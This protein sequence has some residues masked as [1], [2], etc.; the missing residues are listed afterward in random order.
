MPSVATP[1]C[2]LIALLLVVASHAQQQPKPAPLSAG[3]IALPKAFLRQPYHAELG[4]QGGVA[5]FHWAL[6]N[7]SLPPNMQLAPN[8]VVTGV[9]MLVGDFPFDATVTDSSAPPRQINQSLV[10][11]VVA[12]LMARWLKPPQV[13]GARI[14]GSIQV[15]NQTGE[16]FDLTEVVVAVNDVGRATALGY[17]HFT[18][19]KNTIDF[20]IPFGESPGPGTFEVN[21]DVVAEIPDLDVIHRVRLVGSQKLQIAGP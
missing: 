9:P 17:Q 13:N 15:S 12:P 16:D 21:V 10:L 19:Q 18:L 2:I 20:E 1:R 11:R 5:P 8:G 14:E 6:A 3:S 4:V 7:G